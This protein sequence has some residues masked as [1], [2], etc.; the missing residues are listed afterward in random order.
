MTSLI[1]RSFYET[2]CM[3]CVSTF[4][5][6]LIGLPLSLWLNVT[7]EGGLSPHKGIYQGVGAV[8][9]AIR[10]IPYVI[11]TILILPFTKL[12][13]GTSIG[14]W[15]VVVPLS[16]A[17][18]LLVARMAEDA[19]RQVPQGLIEVGL[20]AGASHWQIIRS[21]I[22]PEALPVI[23]A[24]STTIIINLIGFSAMAGA[25]GGGGLGNLALTYGYQRYDVKLMLIIVAILIVLVQGVQM[26]G[27]KIVS[28]LIK[29]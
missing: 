11:L 18:G 23:V 4:F 17:G 27:D 15:A 24:G 7:A 3:V 19:L 21:V 12:L 10:S 5:S 22:L 26:I 9:N 20:A 8:I 16:I 29:N 13:V 6:L 1:L 14:T 25:V 28:R 2:L